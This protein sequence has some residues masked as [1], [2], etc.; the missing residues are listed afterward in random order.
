MSSICLAVKMIENKHLRFSKI[1]EESDGMVTPDMVQKL[2]S[3]LILALEYKMEFDSAVDFIYTFL[4]LSAFS[5]NNG[6]SLEG[7]K[8]FFLQANPLCYNALGYSY[9]L[10]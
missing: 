8:N 2:E 7:E 10:I 9:Q 4:H 6:S 3:C 5:T 1:C